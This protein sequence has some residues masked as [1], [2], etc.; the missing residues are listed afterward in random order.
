[1]KF[2]WEIINDS[3]GSNNIF[4]EATY[5]AKVIGGWLI[6]FECCSDSVANVDDPNA[7]YDIRN[8]NLIFVPDPNHEWKVD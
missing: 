5:R 7:D 1:M 4:W 3:S 2:E 8:H 6:R